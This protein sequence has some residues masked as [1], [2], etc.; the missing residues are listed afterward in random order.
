MVNVYSSVCALQQE[1]FNNTNHIEEYD[2]MESGQAISQYT[3]DRVWKEQRST[4]SL[5]SNCVL[6]RAFNPRD[7]LSVP[8]NY[9]DWTSVF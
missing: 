7:A 8:L 5:G 6:T 9:E 2:S 3:E 4:S 1:V